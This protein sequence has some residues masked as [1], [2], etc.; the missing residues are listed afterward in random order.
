MLT[1]LMASRFLFAPVLEKVAAG[2]YEAVNSE[3]YT[4]M[5]TRVI[6]QG[7]SGSDNETV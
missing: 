7:I 4:K 5:I 3:V 6:L 1:F 2:S